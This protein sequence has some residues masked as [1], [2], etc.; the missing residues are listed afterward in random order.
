MQEKMFLFGAI[1]VGGGLVVM[2]LATAIAPSLLGAI[3][4]VWLS[5]F[6]IGQ[7]ALF[8]CPHCDRF[9]LGWSTPFVGRRCEKCGKDY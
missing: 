5:I 6:A 4:L 7:F 9:A 3:A 2:V 8:R 1:Y